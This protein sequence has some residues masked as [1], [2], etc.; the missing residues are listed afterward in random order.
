MLP[1]FDDQMVSVNGLRL[2]FW[3]AGES[4]SPVIC[5]HGLNGCVEN[6]RWTLGALA[7]RHRAF[8]LDGP[9]HGLS[10][11]DPRSADLRFM[12]DLILAFM[13]SQRLP[14]A[15]LIAL[16]GGGLAALT[17]AL[18]A[19]ERVQRL[20]LVDS[21]GLGRGIHPLMRLA[22]LTRAP[23][24]M[25]RFSREQLRFYLSRYF[26]ADARALTE[27]MLD[28]FYTNT[29]RE[30][31][32]QTASRLM[33]WGVNL[34]GQ[35]F[36][37]AH[38]LHRIQSPTLIVWGRQDRMIPVRHAYRAARRIPQARLLIFDPCG[39]VPPLERAREFSDAALA[40]L[41]QAD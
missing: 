10:Q 25:P 22:S 32:M 31:T 20:M 12:R 18:D 35:R 41:A 5:L 1:A 15:S 36:V 34:W 4:G 3:Q 13:D 40:H 39:H 9:G 7:Q 24:A 2:R 16:S 38:R 30:H 26:F 8:A 27:P 33:R 23:R 21:A 17:L 19:P 29:G 14:R 11:P 37:F 28:D 6:W